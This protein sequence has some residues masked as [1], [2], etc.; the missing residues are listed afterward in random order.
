[1]F[2]YLDQRRAALLLCLFFLVA[3]TVLTW[4]SLQF[5]AAFYGYGFGLAML[6][7]SGLGIAMLVH[8]LDFLEYETFMLQPANT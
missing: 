6:L 4:G 7:T 3:N 2:Y 8:K 1:M 5:G